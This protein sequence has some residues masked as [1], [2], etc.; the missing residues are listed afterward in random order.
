M[1]TLRDL[2]GDEAFFKAVREEVYGTDHPQP[3]KFAP[4]YGSTP[5]FVKLASQAS[6]QRSAVV[7]RRLYVPEGFAGTAGHARPAT[8]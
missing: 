8:A 6:G 3:G 2:I 5:E 7:F 4:R 1:H